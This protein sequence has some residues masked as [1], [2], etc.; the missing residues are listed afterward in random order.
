METTRISEP[1]PV[2]RVPDTT[3][4]GLLERAGQSH[5]TMLAL[6]LT[7]PFMVVLDFFIVNVAI[8]SLSLDLHAGSTTIEWVVAGYGLTTA[9]GLVA[10]GRLGDRAG[11]MRVF[12]AGMLVFTVASAVCGIAPSGETLVAARLVQGLGAALVTPQVLSILSVVYQGKERAR[13]FGV[14]GMTLGL[15]AVLGQLIGGLLIQADLLGLGW[16]ACFLINVP[17]GLV[18]LALVP[19]VVPESRVEG[20]GRLDLTGMG[21]ITVGLAAV[22]LPLIEGREQ[23]WP[24]WTWLCLAASPLILGVFGIH[25]G[26]LR[27]RGGEP[28]LDPALFRERA[29]T[30]GLLT[31]LTFFASMASFF[32]VLAL[33]L[34][35]GRGL[36][37][38]QA[39]LVFTILAVAYLAAS[40]RA[41]ELAARYGRRLPALGGVVLA[42]GHATL[43]ATVSSIGVTSTVLYLTPGLLLA[44]A[45][46]GLVLTPL[47]TTVLVSLPAERAGAASGALATMQNVGNALGVALIGVVFFDAVHAGYAHAFVRSTLVLAGF[48][49]L[50][51]LFTR[52]LPPHDRG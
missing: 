23:G 35:P 8:P 1:P 40:M 39:G 4:E 42:A 32:L 36:D 11:R 13:A 3:G 43:A 28:L 38:L 41:P 19:R 17:I 5:W 44:G 24:L 52:M 49:L 51:A 2:L 46:M 27:N 33:Y 14:Y 12:W 16:R 31:T 22:V 47:T 7:A 18:A 6:L 26:R 20:A 45:G 10:A 15:A 21:L 30:A 48:G 34:Q 37:A 50:L 9:I 25:Q 29:F